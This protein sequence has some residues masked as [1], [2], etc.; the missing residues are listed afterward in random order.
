MKSL[1]SLDIEYFKSFRKDAEKKGISLENHYLEIQVG[2]SGATE[3]ESDENDPALTPCNA[4]LDPALRYL[5][6]GCGAGAEIGWLK[7]KGCH[8]ITGLDICP[9]LLSHCEKRYGIKTILGDMRDTGITSGGFDVVLTH[10][11]LHHMFYPFSAMEEMARIS[12]KMV[13][14]L[15]EPRRILWKQAAGNMMGKRIISGACIYE[16]QFNVDDVD[17]YMMFSGFKPCNVTFF[18]ESG[19]RHQAIY[20]FLSHAL[21]LFGNRFSAIYEKFS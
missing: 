1:N 9:E 21:P 7:G 14:I 19:I 4:F 10:R 6:L 8:N 2:T 5:V 3:K 11:S 15:N 16:Y 18:W 13:M 20:R 12:S 17:R